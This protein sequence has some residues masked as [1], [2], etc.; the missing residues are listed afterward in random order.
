MNFNNID[1]QANRLTN[2]QLKE[3]IYH[4]HQQSA[5]SSSD[6]SVTNRS[7]ISS[8]I[9]LEEFIRDKSNLNEDGIRD[10]N[11]FNITA[12]F[13]SD[14]TDYCIT[15]KNNKKSSLNQKLVALS[16]FLK[17]LV[18]TYRADITPDKERDINIVIESFQNRGTIE[19]DRLL[20]TKSQLSYINKY[21]VNTRINHR[22]RFLAIFLLF[23]DTLCKREELI[24]FKISDLHLDADRPYISS[25]IKGTNKDK[26]YY[27]EDDTVFALKNYLFVREELQTENDFLFLSNRQTKIKSETIYFA[28]KDIFIACGF[29]YKDENDEMK[30]DYTLETLR[31]SFKNQK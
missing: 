26:I 7:Y 27:L 25:L 5:P 19:T 28:F 6:I 10:F 29:G 15:V 2:A 23:R 4:R 31:L 20:F 13:V 14:Y 9:S 8:Y 17:Y 12:Q 24:E 1:V 21:L 22:E 16:S 30:T 11:F 18:K 3:Y